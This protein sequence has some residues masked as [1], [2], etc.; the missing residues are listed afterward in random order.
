[1]NNQRTHIS[2]AVLATLGL[3]DEINFF[4][5]F[6]QDW[7]VRMREVQR[8]QL[9]VSH[10]SRT[11]GSMCGPR[12]WRVIH[13]PFASVCLSL[14]TLAGTAMAQESTT[15]SESPIATV[16]LTDESVV[17]PG[18]ARA[19]PFSLQ[20][21]L[22]YTTA[23]FYRGIL[24]EDT[25]FILQPAAKL[26]VNLYEK[27]DLK[28][29]GLLGVWNSFHGQ[30]TGAQSHSDFTDY[31]Y[32]ADLVAGF[33]LTKGKVS[34]TGTYSFLTSPSDAF[35]TVQELNFTLAYDDSDLLGKWAIY[36]YVL[37]GIETG[38]DGSDGANTQPGTY[39]ELGVAPGFSIDV[40]KA[41]V[42]ISFPMSV[43]LS[44]HDYYQDAAGNDDTFGF[45]QVGVKASV[46]LPFTERYGKWTL[47]AGV[48]AI[49][50]GDHT[51]QF[52]GGDRKQL[53]GSV[54]LQLNF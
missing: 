23:Y 3:R 13:R 8:R 47:N 14:S 50:L 51:A 10:K 25:G 42:A 9:R 24:Q 48:S 18:N 40:G 7:R 6:I 15:Q 33:T 2:S 17:A 41:P 38:A 49:F 21:N 26:T 16:E 32:E 19:N 1:M 5:A 4:R 12:S 11:R 27:N 37:F 53:V 39:L 45:V 28:I 29:D 52:N 44:L 46:P 36:P 20:L 22:D 54:G 35:E 30:K 34:L 43:G 31:W